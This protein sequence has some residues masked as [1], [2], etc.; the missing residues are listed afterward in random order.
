MQTNHLKFIV[1]AAL[2][3][4][5]SLFFISGNKS[6]PSEQSTRE[7]YIQH[8]AGCHGVNL[9]RFAARQWVYGN[10]VQ[11]VSS[12]IKHGRPAIG[13][14]AY[15]NA[16]NDDQIVAMSNYMIEEVAKG[17]VNEPSAFHANDI[18]KSKEF[19]FALEEIIGKN[20]SIPWGLAFLPNGDLLVTDKSGKLFQLSK[21]VITNIEGLP[22]IIVKGQ[23][24]LMEVVVHPK[25]SSNS[26]IYISYA[27]GETSSMVNTTIARAELKN[28]KLQNLKK[29]VHALPNSNS[30]VH[31]GCRM[32]FDKNGYL[33]FSIGERG[34]K[35]NAQDL[36]N[37]CGKIH[38]VFDD[39][40]IPADNPFV[41]TPKAI[42]SIWSYGHRNPQGLYYDKKTDVIWS[43]EH[44]PRGGDELNIIKKGQNYG[45]PV[46]SFGI[47]YD[48]TILTP[49][50]AKKGM[51]QPVFYWIPSIAP[52]S[53]TRVTGSVY[54]GWEGDFFSGSLSF[55]YLERSIM[56]NNK[57]IGSE[58]LLQKI[59]R[60]RNVVEGPDGFIYVAVEKPG[61]VYKLVP[62]SK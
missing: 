6:T 30:G 7:L 3:F 42:G 17:P 52:S 50:T 43:N 35:E 62:I 13:M 49:D 18:I 21:G 58:K 25:F 14:P 45:W 54:K 11:D 34:R 2:L 20:L 27:D 55:D 33:F 41:K 47:N 12:T 53:L 9:D 61:R 28:G 8:C 51:V 10:S 48:G 31:F 32:I 39:G 4:F 15:A 5:F 44:G 38:R 57:V 36:S 23:G 46:I 1:V 60:V 56:K 29:I 24:G 16:M 19:S 59:G 37:Y 40:R 22:K 26:L